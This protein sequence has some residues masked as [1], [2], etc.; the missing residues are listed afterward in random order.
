MA[1]VREVPGRA[2]EAPLR[3]G[4]LHGGVRPALRPA[5]APAL[6]ANGV[7]ILGYE[8]DGAVAPGAT[9][10]WWVGWRVAEGR[11]DAARSYHITNQLLDA[12]GER[13]AQADAGT[14]PTAA[15]AVGDL[16]VQA[17]T[18]SLPADAPPGPYTMRVG[19]YTFPEIEG[20]PLLD[21]AGLPP[22]RGSGLAR[23]GPSRARPGQE[24]VAPL[25]RRGPLPDLGLDGEPRP[26]RS[27]TLS[28]PSCKVQPS[29]MRPGMVQGAVSSMA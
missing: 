19:M 3:V 28:S 26:G 18:L 22:P 4:L 21:A 9:F 14:L 12:R 1:G 2:G 13:L 17:F 23:S 20:Q 11:Y 10:T 6:L 8:A 29:S 5:P 7:E 27:G 25:A 24:H 15:W 16:V